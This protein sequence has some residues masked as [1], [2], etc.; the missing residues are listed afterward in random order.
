MLDPADLYQLSADVPPLGAPVLVQA[1]DGFVDA[2]SVRQ[3]VRQHLLGSFDSRGLARFAH[4]ELIDYRARRPPLT[5]VQD[6]WSA[7]DEPVLALHALTDAGGTPFLLLAGPEPDIQWE[8]FAGAVMQLVDRLGVRLTIG[9]NAIPMAVPHTRPVGMTAHGTRPELVPKS[10]RWIDTVQVP[11]S[12]GNLLEYRLGAAGRDA[13]GFAVHV[14]HYLAQ[15]EFAPAAQFLLEQ[16]ERASG[17]V[18]PAGELSATADATLVS[19]AGQ[20]A[21]SAEVAAAVRALEVQYDAFVGGHGR[22]LLAE[23]RTSLPTADELGAE[24]E[25]FLADQSRRPEG[26]D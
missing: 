13:I 17:L 20:L 8:R 5:F 4:D 3:I 23:G 26:P 9:L 21:D 11:S 18:L 10:E 15:V 24:L 1:L 14:P 22:G 6:R 16:V 12:A 19:I 25:Q 2:G 7:Y